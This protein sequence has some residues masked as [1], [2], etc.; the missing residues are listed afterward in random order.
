MV[1]GT[2]AFLLW[3]VQERRKL[4]LELLQALHVFDF[5]VQSLRDCLTLRAD[6]MKHVD[7]A[8]LANHL[9]RLLSSPEMRASLRIAH[10][11]FLKWKS[12]AYVGMTGDDSDIKV[13][14]QALDRIHA[15][16][17]AQMPKANY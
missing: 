9:P 15:K 17:T 16:L 12:N 5:F 11:V 8:I 6:T 10:A 13:D 14:R 7:I 1:T 3:R 2:I 4:H